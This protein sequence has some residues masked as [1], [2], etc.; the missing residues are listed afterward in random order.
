MHL[1]VFPRRLWRGS[2]TARRAGSTTRRARVF[3]SART[4]EAPSAGAARDGGL[5]LGLRQ[6]AVLMHR[7]V[8]VKRRAP[9][10]TLVEVMACVVLMSLLVLGADMSRVV[11]YPQ[12]IYADKGVNVSSSAYAFVKDLVEFESEELCANIT[13]DDWNA[14][15]WLVNRTSTA[16]DAASNASATAA[17]GLSLLAGLVSDPT[18]ARAAAD[19]Q[20][21][22]VRRLGLVATV[23]LE[24]ALLALAESPSD[25]NASLAVFRELQSQSRAGV[26]LG[27]DAN[28]TRLLNDADTSSWDALVKDAV[29]AFVPIVVTALLGD[30]APLPVPSFDEFVALA[31][32][33][34]FAMEANEGFRRLYKRAT[35]LGVKSLGNLLNLG[36]LGFAPDTPATRRLVARLNATHAYFDAHFAGVWPTEADALTELNKGG[37]SGLWAVVAMRDDEG[38]EAR[39][40]PACAAG[41]D[42][43]AAYAIRMRFTVV[44]RTHDAFDRWSRVS[45]E[46]LKYYTSGFLSVQNAVDSALIGMATG[47]APGFG[48]RTFDGPRALGPKTVG[49]DAAPVVWGVPFPRAALREN[50]F[51]DALGPLLGLLM[52]LS[53][54][55]PVGM[56][57]RGLVQEKETRTRELM[58]IMGLQSWALAAAH[59]TTYVV[60]FFLIAL[61]STALLHDAVFPT[62]DWTVLF[63]FFLALLLTG[64]PLGFLVS[65]FFSRARLAS[66]VGPFA[67]FTMGMPRYVFFDSEESQALSAKRW[68]CLLTP[69]AF[70]FAAD[71]I[72]TREGA[73]RGVTWDTLYDDPFSLGEIVGLA[74]VG[75]ILYAVA[76]WY[77]GNVLPSAHGTPLPW[78]FPFDAAYWRSAGAND[79]RGANAFLAEGCASKGLSLITS[80]AA[81]DM[82]GV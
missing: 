56:L 37:K 22:L 25:P 52:C 53:T 61:F 62:T 10:A 29:D 21:F 48:R 82:A 74:C 30:D 36:A 81:D 16:S 35:S 43:C 39:G 80:D 33:A 13:D 8:L 12:R 11:N 67:L 47:A 34:T 50:T 75:G 32:V 28:W 5:K 55:Y 64:I 49:F 77:L 23:A 15:A 51:Y 57:I 2:R 27:L 17:D 9:L 6:F 4:M 19:T 18:A 73:A 26:P 40:T 42:G 66:I 3:T 70:T 60:V 63:A 69:T 14:T 71:L 68:A 72:A 44:P 46:H 31:R 20:A 24:T 45:D 59:A 38:D 41:D 76:A 58:S 54:L 78:W 7:Q 65:A 1:V 79:A